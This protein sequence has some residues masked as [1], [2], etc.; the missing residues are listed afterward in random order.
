FVTV[1]TVVQTPPPVD[2]SSVKFLVLNAAVSPPVP[3]CLTVSLLRALLEPRLTSSDFAPASA[4]HHLSLLPPDTLP[5]TALD[6][7]SLAL[8]EAC[9]DLAG[10]F[11]ARFV[12]L[13]S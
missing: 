7:P 11:S 3:A 12:P 5:L 6:G 13:P 9:F 10:L 1:A 4:E 8:Q 2:T